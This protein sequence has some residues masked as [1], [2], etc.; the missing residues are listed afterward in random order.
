[1]V[2]MALKTEQNQFMRSASW[3]LDPIELT[4]RSG[5]LY[6]SQQG[7]YIEI[8]QDFGSLL[9]HISNY[10]LA[11]K[12]VKVSLSEQEIQLRNISAEV[13]SAYFFWVYTY[14]R[15]AVLEQQQQIISGI[16]RI[17]ELKYDKGEIDLLE[18][19][20]LITEAAYAETQLNMLYDE[21]EISRNKL[22]QLIVSDREFVPSHHELTMYKIT[23]SS[24]TSQ[25]SNSIIATYYKNLVELDNLAIKSKSAAFFPEISF[26]IINQYIT[27]YSGLWAW[28]V[29]FSF[30]VWF[31]AKN[32]GIKQTRIEAKMAKNQYEYQLFAVS[33]TIENLVLELD[34]TFK[35][36]VYYDQHA[37]LQAR[38]LS[39]TAALQL[40]NEEIEFTEYAKL[41]A[42]SSSIMLQYLKVLNRYN[43]T[44]IQLE[45]YAN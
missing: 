7:R 42:Q 27:P 36:L 9:K 10:K 44:A 34:K 3:D 33:T 16:E 39:E 24:D 11:S 17:A 20:T 6:S 23:K 18:K 29:G 38:R 28:Q 22:K 30:P 25:Y 2:N 4:Y 26:G 31:F 45:F 1:M 41:M 32:A 5:E 21:L 8:N 13:K 40:Q 15:L 19:T 43:Q 37:L 35:E 14:H 12:Q